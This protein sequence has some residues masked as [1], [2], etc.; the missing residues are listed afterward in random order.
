MSSV[1]TAP[2]ENG[3]DSGDFAASIRERERFG[4]LGVVAG[5]FLAL[6]NLGLLSAS[7][8]RSRLHI[9]SE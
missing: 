2:S 9:S 3:P 5:L 4:V 7:S 8:L 6:S 1:P